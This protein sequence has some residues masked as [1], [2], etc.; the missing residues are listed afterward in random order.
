MPLTCNVI[1]NVIIC[2]IAHQ[3]TSHWQNLTVKF[4]KQVYIVKSY[5]TCKSY[6]KNQRLNTWF[7]SLSQ[8]SKD[9]GLIWNFLHIT[10]ERATPVTDCM[11]YKYNTVIYL[12]HCKNWYAQNLWQLFVWCK[13]RYN[14]K[15]LFTDTEVIIFTTT[16]TA[17]FN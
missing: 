1:K 5:F 4:F 16:T 11:C 7:I 6:M 2:S 15:Y 17:L 14:L 3:T 9:Y 10:S 12:S 8:C 13:K